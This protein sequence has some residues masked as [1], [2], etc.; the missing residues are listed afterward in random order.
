MGKKK[1]F[2][3]YMYYFPFIIIGK[4]RKH[5]GSVSYYGSVFWGGYGR[6]GWEKV[7]HLTSKILLRKAVSSVLD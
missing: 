4:Q 1:K 3:K 7:H 2:S 6:E 5:S